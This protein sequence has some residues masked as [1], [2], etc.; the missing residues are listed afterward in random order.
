[1]AIDS[2]IQQ[3]EQVL[4][5]DPKVD[6]SVAAV[7]DLVNALSGDMAE[8][9][10]SDIVQG[11]LLTGVGL[12]TTTRSIKHTLGRR[13]KG[14]IVIS[15]PSCVQLE[16]AST[17]SNPDK[18]IDLRI[19]N[20]ERFVGVGGMSW[21]ESSAELRNTNGGRIEAV[22]GGGHIQIDFPGPAG[23]YLL[24]TTL[25]GENP[26]SAVRTVD[27]VALREQSSHGN[28]VTDIS[29]PTEPATTTSLEWTVTPGSDVPYQFTAG[30]RGFWMV[31]PAGGAGT[32]VYVYGAHWKW[33]KA[34]EAT[35]A[36]WVF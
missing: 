6:R 15:N 16:E 20:E 21:I 12:T 24:E 26:G 19:L 31:D 28:T 30:Y 7:R 34:S 25:Y 22:S 9:A 23:S 8:V 11:Q 4:T 36:L 10:L 13:M 5:G 32:N 2:R 18:Q 29:L 1:M 27:D 3:A 17:Q 35:V 33:A 14:Y